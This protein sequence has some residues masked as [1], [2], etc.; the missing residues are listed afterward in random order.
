MRKK[1]EFLQ[2]DLTSLID[3]VFLLLVF[4]MATSVFKKDELALNLTLPK[5]GDGASAESSKLKLLKFTVTK[6]KI[7][8]NKDVVTLEEAK[9]KIKQ[10]SNKEIP[11]E[12]RIDQKVEY[13][14]VIDV[15]NTVKAEGFYNI[16]LIT[17]KKNLSL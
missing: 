5:T 2:S 10:I 17:Q 15:L 13:Q 6:D 14:R 3:V 11:I 12:L 16:E 8:L 4:F 9:E 7:A 1:R